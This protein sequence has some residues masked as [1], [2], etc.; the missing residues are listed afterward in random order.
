MQFCHEEKENTKQL[1]WNEKIEKSGKIFWKKWFRKKLQ[2]FQQV[3]SK[4][5]FR[6]MVPFLSS[7]HIWW[8]DNENRCKN[9]EIFAYVVLRRR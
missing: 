2:F 1:R 7:G 3:Y 9:T 6:I 8:L 4:I 5:C